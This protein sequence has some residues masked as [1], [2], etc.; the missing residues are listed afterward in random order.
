MFAPPV[1][2]M[3]SN[4]DND[5]RKAATAFCGLEARFTWRGGGADTDTG[6]EKEA[7][8][9]IGDGFAQEWVRSP[10]SVDI[11]KNSVSAEIGNR[12]LNVQK[13]WS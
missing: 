2:R 10:G 9:Y 7:V 6:E 3:L 11:V 8:L 12:V 4:F 1:E 5:Y 13:N